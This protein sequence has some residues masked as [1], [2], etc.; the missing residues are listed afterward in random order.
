MRKLVILI[1]GVLFLIPLSVNAD[2][3][4]PEIKSYKATPI[5]KE[6]TTIY[7]KIY[8]GAVKKGTLKYGEEVEIVMEQIEGGKTYGYFYNYDDGEGGYVLLSEMKYVSKVDEID[9]Q[10]PKCTARVF[11]DDGVVLYEG[12]SFIYDKIATISKGEIIKSTDYNW[13]LG[14]WLYVEYKGKTGYVYGADNAVGILYKGTT[15]DPN[16]TIIINDFYKF[17]DWD[18]QIAYKSGNDYKIVNTVSKGVGSVIKN[19]SDVTVT[20]DLEV[21]DKIVEGSKIGSL[22]K[23]DKV[24]ILLDASS[25]G[26]RFFLIKS[27]DLQGWIYF[28]YEDNHLSL[29]F[30]KLKENDFEGSKPVVYDGKEPQDKPIVDPNEKPKKDTKKGFFDGWTKKEIIMASIIGAAV[31]V[32]TA[33]VTIILV[34]KKKNKGVQA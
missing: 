16:K 17:S 7:E 14:E 30:D 12:P 5:S 23:G 10:T 24:E 6:G 34:N 4:P 32:I 28:D 29:N 2:M 22:K 9:E 3:G 26:D 21:T 33:F 1:L 20:K 11:A 18:G 13:D 15:A 19:A 8:D 25:Y 31:I 27:G